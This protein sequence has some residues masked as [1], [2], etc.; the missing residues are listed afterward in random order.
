MAEPSGQ[1]S[2]IGALLAERLVELETAE[3]ERAGAKRLDR[4]LELFEA[5]V[6]SIA[7]VLAAWTGFQAAKWSGVQANEFSVAGADRVR[8]NALFAADGQQATIDVT[9]F[10]QWLEAA[11]SEGLL[12][13]LADG[14]TSLESDPDAL[15]GVLYERFSP[16]FQAAFDAWIAASPLSSAD[17][18]PTPFQLPEYEREGFDQ[19]A[20]LEQQAENHAAAARNANQR[21]DN[22]V[23]MTVLLASVLLFVGIGSKMDTFR[24]R[25]FLLVAGTTLLLIAIVVS[26]F[27]P[28]EI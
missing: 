6:L 12:T 28:K 3:A 1:D 13:Q 10:A 15:S 27:F 8:A 20:L 2:G 14:D 24:A 7:A 11:E 18:P 5:I 21:S 9:A 23:V 26:A 19:A 25:G 16:N 4:K 22:Y 17:A